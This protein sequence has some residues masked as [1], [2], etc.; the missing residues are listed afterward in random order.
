MA[1]QLKNV[2]TCIG[3]W[4]AHIY[5]HS[6]IDFFT[7]NRVDDCAKRKTVAHK[8]TVIDRF[9]NSI[10]DCGSPIPTYTDYSDTTITR[11]GTDS[12]YCVAD[13]HS[14]FSESAA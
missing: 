1:M 11:G 6:F 7:G 12:R 13:I 10:S 5:G 3:S 2:L 8:A 9:K 4:R 14:S